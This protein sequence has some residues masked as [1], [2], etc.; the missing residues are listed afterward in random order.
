MGGVD[1][2]QLLSD[3]QWLVG[4]LLFVAASAV[5]IASLTTMNVAQ[6]KELGD[7]LMEGNW[8]VLVLQKP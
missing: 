6:H 4:D 3:Q 5:A 1:W 2:F 8:P 7:S